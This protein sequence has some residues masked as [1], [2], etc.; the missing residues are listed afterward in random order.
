MIARRLL[1]FAGALALAGCDRAPPSLGDGEPGPAL[2]E[3]RSADGA[4]EGWLFGTVHSLP[5]GTPWRTAPLDAAIAQADLLVVEAADLDRENLSSIFAGLAFDSPQGTLRS[6]ISPKFRPEFDKL[7][8]EAGV[9]PD[10]LDR[11]E[12]WA[13][14]LALAQTAQAGEGSN[15]ADLALLGEFRGRPVEE[16]E[17][18]KRQLGIFD[19]LPEKEQRDLIDAIIVEIASGKAGDDRLTQ[20]WLS[21]DIDALARKTGEGMLADPEL[22][23]A[24]LVDRN[25]AWTEALVVMLADDAQPLV[26]VGAG[27]LAGPDSIAA[28]LE[29]RGFIIRRV[30]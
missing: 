17:G 20:D 26:A 18:A 9:N 5:E 23:K 28:M 7:V 13:A 6:R 15:G 25:R 3:V 22:R 8:A 14:A 11:M 19:Q 21:G 29:Q 1:A 30:E 16:L 2:W 24:L 4:L 12:T 27:H 10:T